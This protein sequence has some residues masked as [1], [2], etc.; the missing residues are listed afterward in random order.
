[1]NEFSKAQ[2]YLPSDHPNLATTYNNIGLVYENMDEYSKAL[3]S[4]EKDLEN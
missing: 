1:M 4:D 2:N 3:Q